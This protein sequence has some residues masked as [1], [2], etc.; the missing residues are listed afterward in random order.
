MASITKT[1]KESFDYAKIDYRTYLIIGVLGIFASLSNIIT[2]LGNTNMGISILAQIIGFIFSAIVSGYG[3]ALAK[4]NINGNYNSLPGI[5]II[6]NLIDGIKLYILHFIYYIIPSIITLIICLIAGG[7][8]ILKMV[9]ILTATNY[10]VNAIPQELYL[11]FAGALAITIIAGAILFIIFGSL[12]VYGVGRLAKTNSLREGIS[13]SESYSELRKV[14]IPHTIAWLI[15]IVITLFIL[16][17]V[18]GIIMAVPF[19]GGIIGALL[20]YPLM[21]FVFYGS[22]GKFYR[23][24]LIE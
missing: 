14:G 12:T 16:G 9:D 1:I 17:I 21:T 15:L 23:N 19:V 24:E 7:N 22:I 6:E 20:M 2:G 13:F 18:M 8:T 10:N 3:L 5:S 11:S 4:E